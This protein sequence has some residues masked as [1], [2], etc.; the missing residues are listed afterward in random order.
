MGTLMKTNGGFFPDF[1]TI[2]ED[3]FNRDWTNRFANAPVPERGTLP[4]V[5]VKETDKSFELEVAAPGMDKKDFKIEL[6]NDMLVISAEKEQKTEEKEGKYT[7]Q[8]FS[9]SSF[10]RSFTL[11][12]RMVEIEKI[13][14]NYKEGILYLHIPKTNEAKTKPVQQIKIG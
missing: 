13:T 2:F 5:N 11:P 3:F 6:D 4:S 14:A 7:R 9:Y 12:E 10:R 1:P 8:E